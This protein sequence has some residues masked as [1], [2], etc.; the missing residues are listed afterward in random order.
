M[1][2]AFKCMFD[3]VRTGVTTFQY[4]K[5]SQ[6]G[7]KRTHAGQ[8]LRK[9]EDRLNIT[10]Y[11]LNNQHIPLLKGITLPPERRNGLIRSV[12][13]LAQA[14]FLVNETKF[15]NKIAKSFS[16]TIQIIPAKG[17]IVN[18]LEACKNFYNMIRVGIGKGLSNISD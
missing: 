18:A 9:K 6:A 8:I 16:E 15:T 4:K 17:E 11:G 14:I 1:L 2:T 12:G 5:A 3:E 13:P 10:E 7:K